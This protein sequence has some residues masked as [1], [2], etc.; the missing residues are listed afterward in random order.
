MLRPIPI[1]SFLLQANRRIENPPRV[2]NPPYSAEQI[3]GPA[4]EKLATA[5][6]DIPAFSSARRELELR[7]RS[8]SLTKTHD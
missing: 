3:T 6:V 5:A 4:H 1:G 8:S 2:E 7:A